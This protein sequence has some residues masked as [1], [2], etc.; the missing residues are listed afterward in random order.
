M[1]FDGVIVYSIEKWD[2][3]REMHD[4]TM[5][6]SVERH[7]NNDTPSSKIR[8]DVVERRSEK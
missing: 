4:E 2:T 3:Q 7:V 8:M 5:F 1:D 6:L